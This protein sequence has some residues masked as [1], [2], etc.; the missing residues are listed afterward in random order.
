[1]KKILCIAGFGDDASMFEQLTTHDISG[2]VRFLP[3]DLPGFGAPRLQGQETTLDALAAAL[4]AE[5]RALGAETVLA[6]SVASI[7][8]SIAASQ[9]GSPLSTILSLEGNL[10]PEDAYFSG[11][12]AGYNAP[13][14][15][16][17]AFLARL[18]DMKAGDPVLERYRAC[19]ETADPVALWELG[20]DAHTFSAQHSPGELLMASARAIYLY[21]PENL[22][23]TSLAWLQTQDIE[24]YEL[25][26]AS[27]WASVDQ[28]EPL[29]E[30][31]LK[32][33]SQGQ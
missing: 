11:T 25:P 9:A 5:A 28:P 3:T 20:C 31:I 13:D 33:I 7:I 14:E 21:N 6:H 29:L 10:T 1:M 18:D 22:P 8:A 32:A 16:R 24:R 4:N 26:G 15:F 17:S 12:A 19:V 27:H 30:Q 23:E 2:Q